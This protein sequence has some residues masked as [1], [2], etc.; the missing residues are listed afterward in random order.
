VICVLSSRST[1]A[2]HTVVRPRP[3]LPPGLTRRVPCLRAPVETVRHTSLR[4]RIPHETVHEL[5]RS[6]FTPQGNAF[7]GPIASAWF[8]GSTS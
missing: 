6:A 7:E 1:K 2:H 8:S 3:E 4:A 5:L